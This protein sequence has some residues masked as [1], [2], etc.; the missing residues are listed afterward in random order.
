MALQDQ[1]EQE[2]EEEEEEEKQIL[3]Y[4]PQ[5]LFSLSQHYYL[6]LSL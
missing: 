1:H 3:Q 6:T 2:E 4:T 5:P